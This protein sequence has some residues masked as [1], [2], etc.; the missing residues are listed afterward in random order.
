MWRGKSGACSE[1]SAGMPGAEEM[2]PRE[3][4][5]DPGCLGFQRRTSDYK[6]LK[7]WNGG[8]RARKESRTQA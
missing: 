6:C 4:A 8:E 1:E 3:R 2:C 5:K 7:G